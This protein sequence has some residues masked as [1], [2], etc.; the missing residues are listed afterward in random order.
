MQRIG[1]L[2]DECANFEYR[3]MAEWLSVG[4]SVSKLV[5]EPV[6]NRYYSVMGQ[7][8]PRV[9]ELD[10]SKRFLKMHLKFVIF[11]VKDA[12]QSTFHSSTTIMGW[13]WMDRALP[14]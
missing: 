7:D 1:F 8:R 11:D 5:N 10:F 2:L 9:R 4:R 6:W 3:E 12:G 13:D 14:N